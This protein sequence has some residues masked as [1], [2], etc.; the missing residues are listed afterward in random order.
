MGAPPKTA[1][2]LLPVSAFGLGPPRLYAA[3][4]RVRAASR[5][6]GT[7]SPAWRAAEGIYYVKRQV[8]R[9]LKQNNRS[10]R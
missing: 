3:S 10:R 9:Q 7:S 8:F 6:G 4:R 5:Y 2:A 1:A